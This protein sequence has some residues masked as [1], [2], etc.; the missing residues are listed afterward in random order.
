MHANTHRMELLFHPVESL[1]PSQFSL[2]FLLVSNRHSRLEMWWTFFLLMPHLQAGKRVCGLSS[3]AGKKA[4]FKTCPRSQFTEW[5]PPAEASGNK[6]RGRGYHLHPAFPRASHS[7]KAPP[8]IFHGCLD[9]ALSSIYHAGQGG[10]EPTR[11]AHPVTHAQTFL[12]VG[13]ERVNKGRTAS[14]W[15]RSSLEGPGMTAML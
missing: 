2:V 8:V 11:M 15:P 13:G 5:Y 9:L 7:E 14:G 3:L 4:F 1:K 10:W 6:L 12:I